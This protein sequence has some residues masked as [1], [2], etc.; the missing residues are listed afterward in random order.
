MVTKCRIE[1]GTEIASAVET[2]R[3]PCPGC[4]G[5]GMRCGRMEEKGKVKLLEVALKCTQDLG[6]IPIMARPVDPEMIA[7]EKTVC[8]L[9]F[10]PHHMGPHR[11]APGSQGW[12]GKPGQKT[13]FWS[14]F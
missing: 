5:L 9:Q 12:R 10:L 1:N 13:V 3:S 2:V 11:E 6:F 14:S 4:A 7:T 8:Y